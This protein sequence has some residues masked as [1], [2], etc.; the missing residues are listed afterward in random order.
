M[1]KHFF[2]WS[3]FCLFFLPLSVYAQSE[4]SRTSQVYFSPQ[5]GCTGAIVEALSEAKSSIFVQAFSFTS[6]TI[7]D[8][9]IQAHKRGVKVEVIVDKRR[10]RENKKILRRLVGA[11]ISVALDGEHKKAHNKVMIIDGK[12]VITGSFNFTKES[13]KKNAEN[14]LILDDEALARE[15]TDNWQ[16]HREH[17]KP[18]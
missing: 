7:A 9:L 6:N 12:T 15:Y 2:E 5:G 17:S 8:V 14:L 3:I 16:K 13:E 4:S 10:K 18:L 1:R 11:G